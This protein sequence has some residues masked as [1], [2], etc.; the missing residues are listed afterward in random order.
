[1]SG[2][3]LTR[4]GEAR[5]GFAPLKVLLCPN[6]G[7][8]QLSV[9][10]DPK[11]LYK[12]YAYTSSS[13]AMMQAH[14]EAIFQD[15]EKEGIRWTLL[16]IASN[17]GDCLKSAKDHGYLAVMGVEPASNLA[18]Q[19]NA[20]GIPT[21]EWFFDLVSAGHIKEKF[22]H[23]YGGAPGVILARHVFAHIDDW[24]DF[25]KALEW[26]ADDETLACLEIP[27]QEDVLR[28]GSWDSIYHEHISYV[29]LEAIR[30]ITRDTAFEVHKVI[31]Y[32]IHGGVQM[33]MLKKGLPRDIYQQVWPTPV[34][35]ALESRWLALANRKSAAVSALLSTVWIANAEGKVV[36]VF[37]AS[38][39]ATVLINAC[40]FTSREISF[41]TDNSPYK[42]GR[43]VPGTDIP[44]IHEDELRTR[45]CDVLIMS[46]WNFEREVLEKMKWWPGKWIIP[47]PE[48]RVI[49]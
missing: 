28:N 12:D 30:A 16:E 25:F 23:D 36:G 19:S 4:P 38:A 44:V 7:L 1:M 27:G 13:S 46:C 20:D 26:I 40:G 34:I 18:K 37:G 5:Q 17:N 10:V 31:Q 41:V 42:P 11:I 8:A 9:V 2:K 14:Y 39:K 45:K 43:L 22:R 6:C 48:V 24:Q 29:N 47:V 32:P 21:V 33:V 49:G 3:T 15:I 35:T